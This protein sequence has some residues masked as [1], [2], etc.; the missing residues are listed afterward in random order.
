M[1][2]GPKMKP[3]ISYVP[4]I[5]HALTNN[6]QDASIRKFKAALGPK[7]VKAL[8]DNWKQMSSR[9]KYNRYYMSRKWYPPTSGNFAEQ[10]AMQTK[11]FE[12]ARSQLLR[13]RKEIIKK[14]VDKAFL[15]GVG[16]YKPSAAIA[17]D[18]T[19]L[20]EINKWLS[21]KLYYTCRCEQDGNT[22]TPPTIP[23]KKFGLKVTKLKCHD[24]RETGHDEIYFMS[25]VVDGNGNLIT[26]TSNKYS[27]SNTK[28]TG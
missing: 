25:A 6:A 5:M 21:H 20:Y 1:N 18:A 22:D 3:K 11:I 4:I 10:M 15:M 13:N 8:S 12:A 17:K 27:A 19:L 26:T 23:P 9:E 28:V 14:E 24:Q 2:I 7:I 16:N